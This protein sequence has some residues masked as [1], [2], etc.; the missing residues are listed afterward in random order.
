M[1]TRTLYLGRSLIIAML[2]AIGLAA[3]GKEGPPV[4]PEGEPVTYPRTYPTR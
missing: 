4:P 2:L 3:C 1:P